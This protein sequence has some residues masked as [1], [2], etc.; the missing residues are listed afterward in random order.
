MQSHLDGG[1]QFAFLEGL[2]DVAEGFGNFSAFQGSAVGVRGQID[3]R[4][5]EALAKG[6]GGLGAVHAS[7]DANVHQGQ[8][9]GVAFGL[10][11]GIGAAGDYG[12]NGIAELS[13]NVAQILGGDPLVFDNKKSRWHAVT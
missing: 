10:G 7:L 9:G 3:D 2:G 11:Q 12:G 4:N 5:I 13:Q 1:V 8:V 6:T